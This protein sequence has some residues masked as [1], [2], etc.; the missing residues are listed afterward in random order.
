MPR[1]SKAKAKKPRNKKKAKRRFSRFSYRELILLIIGFCL[2]FTL[3]IFYVD[4][5]V[6]EQFE[7]KRFSLP[8]RVYARPLELYEGKY[9][10]TNQLKFEL[11]LLNYDKLAQANNEGSYSQSGNQFSLYTRPFIFWDGEQATKNI[12]FRISN[13]KITQL[14]DENTN[15][16]LSLVRLDPIKIGGIY[17]NK[18]EDRELVRLD[19]VPDHLINALIAVEDKRFYQHHGVDPKAVLRA[20]TTL[21]SGKRIQGGSTITQQLV[22]NF[23]LTQERTISRKLKEMVMALLLELHYEKNDILETYLNEVYFGQDKNR[24]IHGFGLASQFYFSRPIEH[25]EIH[26]SALLIGLLKGPVYYNPR[27]HPERAK[28]RRNLVIN[29]LADQDY[30]SKQQAIY[31]KKQNIAVSKLPDTGQSLYPAF[32]E[33]VIKQL[34]RDYRES[35]LRSEG[36]RIFTTLD[37]YQQKISEEAIVLR[38]NQL[39]KDRNLPSGHLQAATIVANI[40]DGE[41]KAVVGGRDTNF[42]GFNRALDASRQIGSLIKPVIYL[43][44]LNQEDEY[45]L[46]TPIDDSPFTWSENGIEDWQPQNYDKKF[47]GEVPLWLA[48]AKSYNVAAARLGTQLGVK[49]IIKMAHRLGVHKELSPYASSLLGTMELTPYEVTQLYHTIANGGFRT[50]LRAIREVTTIEGEPLSRYQIQTEPAVSNEANYLLIRALQEVVNRGTGSSVKNYIG[51]SLNAAGKTGT[52]DNL[53]DSWF[54]GFTGDKV[55]VVWLGNDDNKSIQ[56]TGASGAMTIWGKIIQNLSSQALSIPQ[57]NSVKYAAVDNDTGFLAVR[58]CSN[59]FELPF[60]ESSLPSDGNYCSAKTSGKIKS[61]F[62]RIFGKR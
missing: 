46:A 31:E 50:P 12:T 56:L 27:R 51:D 30:I 18:G 39:E 38:L 9:L 32:L 29:A 54:A 57:P 45:N 60:N 24:A 42:Q 19:Q 49:K 5:H 20:I 48:L 33:L 36:L 44:A 17:P 23:F 7:G 58:N 61:W 10:T 37:P 47:H 14:R 26:Q 16:E 43:T 22:K 6:V 13:N 59:T 2:P 21:F 15:A 25:L 3:Y 41:I 1:T 35:D 4:R 62:K 52:T 28:K 40:L 11:N 34:K 53:R 55:A 8:A